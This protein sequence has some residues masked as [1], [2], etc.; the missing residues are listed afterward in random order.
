L[1]GLMTSTFA[2]DAL[3]KKGK[4]VKETAKKAHPKNKAPSVSEKTQIRIVA[5]SKH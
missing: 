4:D 1:F 2:P 5:K 3:Y